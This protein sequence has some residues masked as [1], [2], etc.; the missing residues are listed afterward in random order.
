MTI[1]RYLDDTYL[2]ESSARLVGTGRDER[3]SYFLLDQTIFYPQGGGQPSDTGMIRGDSFVCDV[4]QVRQAVEGICHYCAD[5]VPDAPVGTEVTCVVDEE[6]RMLNARCHTA[7]HLLGN[8]VDR[9]HPALRAVKSH[10]FPGEAYVEFAGEGTPDVTALAD[11][12][13]GAIDAGLSVKTF[14]TDAASFQRDYYTLPYH[15]PADKH[16]RA[17]QIG[18]YP[19]VPCGGTHLAD[20][21]EIGELLPTAVK[22]K[23]GMLRIAYHLP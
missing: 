5:G 2:L 1:A 12:L 7:A 18:D 16:F 23:K 8:V 14:E 15:I 10:S 19:P 9:L 22:N 20:I 3:G 17:V 13:R 21:K 4:V 11:A 6:R